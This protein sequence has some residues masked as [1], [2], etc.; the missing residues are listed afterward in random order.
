MKDHSASEAEGHTE[1]PAPKRKQRL[2]RKIT[3]SYLE[4]AALYYLQRFS[5]SSENLRLV[6]TRKIDKS[7]YHH[8]TSREEGLQ[9]LDDLIRRFLSS[10][11]LNDDLY[12]QA[13]VYS[14]RRRGTSQ[15]LIRSKLMQ[16]GLS[17][18]TINE[19]LAILPKETV[20]PELAAAKAYARRRRLGPY[21]TRELQEE[22]R[23]KDLAAMARAGFS[24]AIA[25]KVIGANRRGEFEDG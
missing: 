21:R 12:A 13:R 3:E 23:D 20:D 5:S 7:I 17:E 4:N 22:R 2:P 15:R 6:M 9:M 25:H 14:L 8:G 11:I 10:G 16:K 24:Y 19:A 18:S 1:K